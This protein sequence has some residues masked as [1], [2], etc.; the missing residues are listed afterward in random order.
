LSDA[1]LTTETA[2][3]ER[4]FVPGR[5]LDT[6]TLQLVTD[7]LKMDPEETIPLP[8]DKRTGYVDRLLAQAKDAE[9]K[10]LGTTTLRQVVDDVSGKP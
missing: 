6:I 1:G 5:S 8:D 4:A 7:S 10:I 2:E 3:G 9:G